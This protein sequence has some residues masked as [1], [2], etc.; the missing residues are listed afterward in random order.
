MGATEFQWNVIYKI[1]PWA[2]F[3]LQTMVCWPL[4]QVLVMEGKKKKGPQQKEME[5]KALQ[6]Y[7]LDIL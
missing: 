6:L 2:V 1:R 7:S 5:N 3:G 4:F